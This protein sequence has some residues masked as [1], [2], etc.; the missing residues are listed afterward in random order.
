MPQLV[1]HRIFMGNSTLLIKL[2]HIE[3]KVPKNSHRIT[4]LSFKIHVH[5]LWYAAKCRVNASGAISDA[6]FIRAMFC[7]F[8]PAMP[9]I[10]SEG[11][12]AYCA[13]SPNGAEKW[14]ERD[15]L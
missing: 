15:L 14:V 6:A 8:F 5:P 9:C 3:K 4:V 7:F 2:Q 1:S 11:G 12:L 10:P 13:A